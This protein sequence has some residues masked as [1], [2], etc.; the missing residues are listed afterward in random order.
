MILLTH[1]NDE[2]VRASGQTPQGLSS[3]SPFIVFP[4]GGLA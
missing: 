2:A 3:L 1:P 4:T